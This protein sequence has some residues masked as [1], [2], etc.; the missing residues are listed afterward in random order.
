MSSQNITSTTRSSVSDEPVHRA[1]EREQHGGELPDA[2]GLAAE[3]PA[4]VEH[5]EGAD[6]GHDERHDPRRGCPSAST[7]R[8]RA[9][10][11]SRMTRTEYRPRERPGSGP[12]R[13]RTR[14]SAAAR[15]RRKPGRRCAP[16]ATEAASGGARTRR[17]G[18]ACAA[19]SWSSAHGATGGGSGDQGVASSLSARSCASVRRAERERLR[20]AV[21]WCCPRGTRR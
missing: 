9:A 6:A 7:A 21:R 20:R 2:L 16:R 15:R 1:G 17:G 4:A 14:R 10:G 5:H 8:C 12:R 18:A 3:V 11:S 13:A 19:S